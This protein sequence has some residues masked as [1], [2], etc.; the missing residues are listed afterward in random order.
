MTGA[1]ATWAAAA[2]GPS[3][4]SLSLGAVGPGGDT[5]KAS[6]TDSRGDPAERGALLE[7]I[8]FR[9]HPPGGSFS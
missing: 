5:R 6:A 9:N 2:L 3:P 4:Q 7:W 8:L 1:Q